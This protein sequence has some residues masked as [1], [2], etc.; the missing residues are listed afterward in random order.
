MLTTHVDII[1]LLVRNRNKVEH[2]ILAVMKKLLLGVR[3]GLYKT[4]KK[5]QYVLPSFFLCSSSLG[6]LPSHYSLI[7]NIFVKLK[8]LFFKACF[9]YLVQNPL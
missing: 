2:L 9:Q 7:S 5:G 1:S 3:S 6:S 8:K 4:V